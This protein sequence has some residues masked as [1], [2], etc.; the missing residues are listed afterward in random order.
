MS[1]R[2]KSPSTEELALWRQVT[3]TVEPLHPEPPTLPA[4]PPEPVAAVPA[5]PA[6]RP[7]KA[8]AAAPRAAAPPPAPKLSPLDRRTRARLSRGSLAIEARIDL[9]GF[10][11]AAAHDRLVAFLRGAQADG[12]RLALVITGKGRPDAAPGERGVLRRSVP[13]WLA[14]PDLRMLV[15]GFEPAGRGHGGDGALYVRI[16]RAGRSER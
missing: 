3:D 8:K 2:R 14:S 1:R 11:Q 12:F 6:P 7:R 5:P 15:V 9:H 4:P 10:T 16:R 13:L